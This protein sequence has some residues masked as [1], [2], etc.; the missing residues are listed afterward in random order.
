LKV[1][2]PNRVKLAIAIAGLVLLVDTGNNLW[3]FALDPE[4]Q[5]DAMFRGLWLAIILIS[6]GATAVFLFFAS[7][8]H[9]WARIAF[10]VLTL[11][12]WTYWVVY[13]PVLESYPWWKWGISA[14]LILAQATALLLLFLGAG[15]R[16]FQEG[17]GGKGAL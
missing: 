1:D 11:G 17:S 9:N 15:A 16:W 7:R 4:A 14:S 2:T 8:R 13:P 10:L 5:S 12:Y 3:Q 6:A